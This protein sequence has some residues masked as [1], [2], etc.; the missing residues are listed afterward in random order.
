MHGR[1]QVNLR[2]RIAGV[3]IGLLVAGATLGFPATAYADTNYPSGCD[4]WAREYWKSGVLRDDWNHNCWLGY[5]YERNGNYTTGIQ[6]MLKGR[7]YYTYSIDGLWGSGTYNAVKSYQASKGLA[8]DG[9]VGSNT[10]SGTKGF[11]TDL[12]YAFPCDGYYACYYAPGVSGTPFKKD[13]SSDGGWWYTYP[14]GSTSYHVSFSVYG[15][16]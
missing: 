1:A 13:T 9:I 16:D 12:T 5:S 2:T 6:R 8:Q 15:P 7:G 4:T 3:L 11:R 14:K 10:W